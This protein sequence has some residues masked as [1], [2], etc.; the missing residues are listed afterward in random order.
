MEMM[1][2]EEESEAKTELEELESDKIEAQDE[3]LEDESKPEETESDES[4]AKSELKIESDE[5]EDEESE[6]AADEE[7]LD[8][9]EKY[10]FLHC[11]QMFPKKQR[12]IRA[13]PWK[14]P[15]TTRLLKSKR[16]FQVQFMFK[17]LQEVYLIHCKFIKGEN[18][19][20]YD[21]IWLSDG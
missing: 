19:E 4:A 1:E 5:M 8:K 20:S 14:V 16:I 7:S 15:L 18:M 12:L 3:E 17:I 13:R 10:D 11:G 9:D 2:T 21:M 6:A